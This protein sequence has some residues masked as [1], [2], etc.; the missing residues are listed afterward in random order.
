MEEHQHILSLI[1]DN[2]NQLFLHADAAGLDLLI[3]Q[4][5]HLRN[6]IER[7]ESDHDH[8][9]TAS[10][11]S[12]ELTESMGCEKEGQIIHHLKMYGWTDKWAKEHGFVPA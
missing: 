10:W 12:W 2:E 8:M 3:Q 6:S 7:G 11:G 9:M 4:L 5:Q 1:T